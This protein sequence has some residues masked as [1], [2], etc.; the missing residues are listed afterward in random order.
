[1]PIDVPER[2]HLT[3]IFKPI[4]ACNLACAY[5]YNEGWRDT[6]SDRMSLEEA[7]YAFSWVNDFCR[8]RGVESVKVIWHGGEPLLMGPSFLHEVIGFY[9]KLFSES[10]IAVKNVIQTNATLINED[11][12]EIFR[13]FFNSSIGF[14]FDYKSG[15]RCFPDGRDASDMILERAL[16]TKAQGVKVGAIMVCCKQ[17]IGKMDDLFSFMAEKD[18]AFKFSRPFL[19]YNPSEQASACI[20]SVTDSEYVECVCRLVDIALRQKR[21]RLARLCTTV[22]DYIAAFLL[23]KISICAQRGTCSMS[24]LSIGPHGDIYPCGRFSNNI[25]RVGNYLSDRPKDVIPNLI[26]LCHNY[27]GEDVNCRRCQFN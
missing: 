27:E 19:P 16:W 7:K 25:F 21:A 9:Q 11:H 26:E 17:N 12:I 1:M 20:Q 4:Y 8:M 24:H 5:C 6:R 23:N 14:S 2:G 15:C 13:D 3:L 18:I 22:Q 10:G